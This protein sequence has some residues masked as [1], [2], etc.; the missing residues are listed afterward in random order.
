MSPTRVLTCYFEVSERAIQLA[1][2]QERW[3][4]TFSPVSVV[5]AF[6]D[7]MGKPVPATISEIFTGARGCKANS[8]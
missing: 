5:S 6:A 8:G 1:A 4:N 2:G 7:H 3:R